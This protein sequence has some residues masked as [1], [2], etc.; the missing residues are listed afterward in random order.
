MSTTLFTD[1][2]TFR[3]APGA[4]AAPVRLPHDAMLAEP[5]RARES[6]GSHGGYFPGGHY[7]YAKRWTAP[8][9]A[10]HLNLVFEGVQGRTKV[11]VD[12]VTIAEC[13]SG[14]R[15]FSAPLPAGDHLIEVDV[16]NSEVP[17]SRWYT[18]AGIYRPVWLEQLPAVHLARDGIHINAQASSVDVGVDIGGPAPDG[19]VVEVRVGDA[20]S[21]WAAVVGGRADLRFTVPDAQLWSAEHPHRYDTTVR[22]LDG[23]AELHRRTL[24]VGLRTLHVDAEQG[25]LVNGERVLLRGACVH[26][27]SGVLGAATFRAAEFRRARILKAN[28]YNAIRSSHN[29]ISRDLL[30]A[31]D[32]IGL[33][34]IDELT[35]IWYEPK[36]AHDAS[37]RFAEIWRDDARAMVAKDHAHP[38]VIMYSIGNEITETA[39]ARGVRTARELHDFIAGLDPHRPTTVAVNLVLNVMAARGRSPFKLGEEPEEP[40]KPSKVTS[41]AANVLTDR[42]GSLMRL[43]SRL[44]VA[45]R[46]SRDAFAAAD[47]AGYNYAFGRY[48]GD[49]KRYPGR[50][51]LGSES[52]PGDLPRIWPI[53]ERVPG[54]IGDFMWTGWDYLGEAGIGTWAY[55]DHPGGLHK[56]YP[57]LLAGPGAIDITGRPGAPALLA[58]AVWGE[59]TAPAIAVRPLDHAGRRTLRTAW[60]ATDAVASWAWRGCEGR[61][62]EIEVYSADDEVELLLNGRSLGRRRPR[63]FV[64]RFRTPYRP[65]ELLAVGYRAGRETGRSTLVSAGPARLRL[66]AETRTLAADGQDLAFVHVELADDH[67]T[68][69]MLA[70]DAVTISVTGPGDL[71]GFGSAAPETEE[72]FTGDTHTTYYGR[73]LAVIRAGHRPGPITVSA[74]SRHH[75]AA[76][77][78]LRAT[79]PSSP[80]SLANR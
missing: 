79:A 61:T 40:R 36:T 9:D 19:L 77:T 18:G 78:E 26:H 74:T 14:Y 41:T 43:I 49:R 16:D 13:A 7:R 32:E 56:P 80:G 20:V 3:R 30:D 4:E 69:E 65:G 67:G 51:I 68:V 58:R 27:D 47:V 6:T 11:L 15:E 10:G 37:A 53:V 46:V 17:N 55:G 45:D 73:A 35:D 33:Y 72:T 70:T 66:V 22:L 31:C 39:T 1:G 48:P 21:E 52:M 57:A 50:V 28:G 29:P 76:T 75:G 44:P 24:R 54:V 59:L 60:R 23:D 62:A 34:V 42:L 64:A 2:W 71:A 38:S 25:L 12:G 5:R 63:R 8:V